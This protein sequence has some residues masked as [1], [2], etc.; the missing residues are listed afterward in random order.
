MCGAHE[1]L[2][3][4]G[5]RA[6]TYAPFDPR[7]SPPQCPRITNLSALGQLVQKNSGG[8]YG[9]D[10]AVAPGDVVAAGEEVADGLEEAPH[11]R[12]HRSGWSSESVGIR[13]E[14]AGEEWRQG[15]VFPWRSSRSMRTPH[16]GDPRVFGAK[17]EENDGVA[18]DSSTVTDA[19]VPRHS[20][21]ESA[22]VV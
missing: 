21:F 3:K 20:G 11:L 19:W 1:E 6:T 12:L 15:R 14:V 18:D 7:F 10:V 2:Q 16:G 9:D 17:K 4:A 8:S 5:T 22:S 13:G